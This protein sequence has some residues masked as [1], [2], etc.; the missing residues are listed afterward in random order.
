VLAGWAR[1]D[2]RSQEAAL[3]YLVLGAVAS[4][5][6]L[7]G[8]ALA[9]LATGEVA[10]PDIGAAIGSVLVPRGVVGIALALTLVGLAFKVSLV[11]FHLWTA[12]VYQGAPTNITALMA[13][14]TKAAGF[15]AALRLLLVAFG[16][17]G[18]A[19]APVLAVIAA[20]TML[21]GAWGALVQQD[22]K[23][24][25]AYSSITHAGYA[26]IAVVARTEAGIS[27]TLWYLLTYA[28]GTLGAFGAI[29]AIE[30]RRRGEVT[31]LDLRGLGRTSPALAGLL[32]LSMLSLAG[33]PA[34]AGFIGKLMVFRAGVAAGWTWLVVV[35]VLSSVIAA[36]FYLRIVGV[37]FLEEPDPA[38]GEPVLTGGLAVGLSV[39]GLLVVYLGLQPQLLLQLA[40]AASVVWR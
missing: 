30:R 20:V 7:Y 18:P 8:L 13:A 28:I 14:A 34:T 40:D 31:L 36:G 32:T 4:A 25:L 5:V 21:Y 17:F 33:I 9:Y 15:A 3:K 35:G 29:I 27:A 11:P 24:I 16:P 37:L 2:R 10:L 12:D 1:R 19:W 6:L 23:R 38:R 39:S 22:V 26:A